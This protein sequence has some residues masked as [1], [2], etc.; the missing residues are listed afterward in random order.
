[1]SGRGKETAVEDAGK[2]AAGKKASGGNAA[3]KKASGGNAAGKKSTI[4]NAGGA[5]GGAADGS[6]GKNK[7]ERQKYLP[8]DELAKYLPNSLHMLAFLMGNDRRLGQKCR[9]RTLDDKCLH[10]IC[11]LVGKSP[12]L[13]C[14]DIFVDGLKNRQIN[15]REFEQCCSLR[16]WIQKLNELGVVS[17]TEDGEFYGWYDKRNTKSVFG[18][19]CMKI[20]NPKNMEPLIRELKQMFRKASH[21]HTWSVSDKWSKEQIR[22]VEEH[23]DMLLVRAYFVMREIAKLTHFDNATIPKLYRNKLLHGHLKVMKL[24]FERLTLRLSEKH[25]DEVEQNCDRLLSF[26]FDGL[27]NG[28]Q[29]MR[30]YQEYCCEVAALTSNAP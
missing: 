8:N 25:S 2:K 10:H 26:P 20:I 1:M 19:D 27:E 9:I 16:L 3:G 11:T 14:L 18:I 29:L 5:A 30:I 17:L 13:E 15:F 22:T 24:N 23:W 21:T 7:E 6:G 12:G 28:K 4:C